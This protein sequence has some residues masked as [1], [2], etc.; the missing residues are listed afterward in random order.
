MQLGAARAGIF[1]VAV[2]LAVAASPARADEPVTPQR[3]NAAYERAQV[4][5]RDRK[6]V[7]ARESLLLCSQPKCPGAI[8]ADCGPWLRE[9]ESGMPSVVF[10]ARDSAGKDVPGVKVSVDGTVLSTR[11]GGSALEVD[12]G[13]RTFTFEPEHGKRVD[14]T[15][16][17]NMCD[18]NRLLVVT[19]ADDVAPPVTAS[20][21]STAVPTT[22]QPATTEGERPSV[23]PALVVGGL[24]VA[25]L[26]ASLGIYLDAKGGLATLRDTCAPHCQT[27]DVDSLRTRGIISD[28][29]FGVG[30]AGLGAAG[31]M[32]LL[33]APAKPAAPASVG[34][35]WSVG[36]TAGGAAAGLSGRF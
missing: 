29:A 9:V 5:R 25:A 24:G 32:L 21:A 20:T 23:V 22:P 31:L 6:L 1:V 10:V 28:V 13:E 3:C 2:M 11:L 33:R 26:G 4:L 27:S 16:I 7:A 8:T 34:L 15:L 36:P 18:K 19:I 14:Q 17:F 30:I 12:P 35:Q